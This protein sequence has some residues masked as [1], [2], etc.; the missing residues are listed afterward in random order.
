MR[1]FYDACPT[2]VQS[3]L[4]AA[5]CLATPQCIP[6]NVCPTRLSATPQCEPMALGK[7]RPSELA[8]RLKAVS[9]YFFQRL[10][11]KAQIA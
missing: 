9:F 10:L 2:F 5:V 11:L 7:R 3:L 6:Q 1:T 4:H 8:H